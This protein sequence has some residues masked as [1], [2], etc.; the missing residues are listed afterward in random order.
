MIVGDT[1]YYPLGQL[2]TKGQ[3]RVEYLRWLRENFPAIFA[4]VQNEIP[5]IQELQGL[6]GL[7]DTISSS[8]NSAIPQLIKNETDR[9]LVR[10]QTDRAQA[11]APPAPVSAGAGVTKILTIPVPA[12]G[13]NVGQM[14]P[15]LLGVGAV[16]VLMMMRKR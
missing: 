14:L 13:L 15:I 1:P 10:R 12:T 4:K 2:Q 5:N 9:V 16:A 6:S 7:W 11:G 3:S 8:I